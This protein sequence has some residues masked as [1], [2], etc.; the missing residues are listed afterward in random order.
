MAAEYG[1]EREEEMWRGGHS[2]IP[3]QSLRSFGLSVQSFALNLPKIL[4]NPFWT[5]P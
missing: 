5:R 4:K 3:A 2:S 1:P